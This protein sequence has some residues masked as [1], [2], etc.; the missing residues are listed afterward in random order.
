[1]NRATRL[2]CL[3]LGL[4]TSILLVGGCT[5]EINVPDNTTVI[6][7]PWGFIAIPAERK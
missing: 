4:L 7:T 6:P 1:M 3:G 2:A 5:R